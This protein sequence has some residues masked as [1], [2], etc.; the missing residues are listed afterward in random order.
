VQPTPKNPI[1][2]DHWLPPPP[3]PNQAGSSSPTPHDLY[4]GTE[5]PVT[6]HVVV[7]YEP[8]S[9]DIYTAD[10]LFG[11][12]E[13]VLRLHGWA[14]AKVDRKTAEYNSHL[15]GFTSFANVRS[16]ASKPSTTSA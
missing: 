4:C 6:G 11:P 2:Q 15:L 14:N 12:L 8:T 1:H 10:E 5:Q 3:P 9:R 7:R 13:V 16:G